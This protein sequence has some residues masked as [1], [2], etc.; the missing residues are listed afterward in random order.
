MT[1]EERELRRALNARSGTPSSEFRARLSAALAQDRPPSKLMPALA[2]VAAAI[3]VIAAV[4]VLLLARQS[5]NQSPVGPATTPTPGA[6]ST[7]TTSRV[8]GVLTAPPTPIA[9]PANVQLSAP[10]TNV[11]WALVAKQ[12]LYRSTDRGTT[13]VQRPIVGPAY[14]GADT[15]EMSFVN[16][17][18]G[19]LTVDAPLPLSDRCAL[20]H[21]NVWHTTDA[22]ASWQRL[23]SNGISDYQ[24][25]NHMSFVDSNH[26]FLISQDPTGPTT[27]YR[28]SD[29]GQTWTASASLPPPP[30]YD[31]AFSPDIPAG[32]GMLG[33]PVR[34]FGSTL[35]MTVASQFHKYVYRSIDGGA[36][37]AYRTRAPF[38][39]QDTVGWDTSIGL[40]TAS[41]WLQMMNL[42][43]SRETTDAGVS[44]HPYA[45]DYSQGTQV[46]AEV[47][48]ADSA[49][50]YAT[51][52]GG[53]ARTE[54]GGLHWT[55]IET[56]G[57][58]VGTCC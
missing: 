53:I 15:L 7:P 5:R 50:G 12:Y 21:L 32:S 25:K 22:G 36:T 40:V 23:G 54:D 52:H 43:D 48:F 57:I 19:W 13:W 8:V 30:D 49:V 58:G 42:I 47:V 38:G 11:I 34:A 14:G 16:D 27:V 37:W 20:Q 6:T 35:L 55:V 4:G 45:S 44:W 41:R 26:G 28:T 29:G 18:E 46:A 9:L 33:G 3:L 24:C 31:P 2:A 39:F 1:P 51:V 10:S 17:Q 56:P